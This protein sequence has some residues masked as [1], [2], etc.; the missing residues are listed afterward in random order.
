MWYHVPMVMNCQHCSQE[1]IPSPNSSGKY[2]SR[3]CAVTVNN[4][5]EP[6]R[7]RTGRYN[8]K[9]CGEKIQGR[10]K[11]Y[12]SVP[13][14]I[15]SRN[16]DTLDRFLNGD[17]VTT[18]SGGLPKAVRRFL[19]N[20]AGNACTRCRWSVEN[21]Y[22]R[23]V[24][25]SVDHIDGNCLNNTRANLRVLCYNCHTLTPT[26]NHLNKGNGRRYTPGQRQRTP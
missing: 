23:A 3:S 7:Q 16:Q 12:C 26:F 17:D 22:S 10:G 11:V 1:F 21:P 24:S 18:S 14:G 15:A 4:K 8:C 2:C 5:R 6:K 9:R 13:C 19:L 25:L 20:E